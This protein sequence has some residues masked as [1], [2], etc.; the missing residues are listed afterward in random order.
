M[1]RATKAISMILAASAMAAGGFSGG[2]NAA[3]GEADIERAAMS[4][5]R[6]YGH[7][8]P[9]GDSPELE[10]EFKPAFYAVI[11]LKFEPNGGLTAKHAYF[12]ISGTPDNVDC[13]IAFLVSEDPRDHANCAPYAKPEGYLGEPRVP[14]TNTGP[15]VKNLDVLAFG[16]QQRIYVFVDN[17]NV[18][19]NEKTPVSFTPYGAFDDVSSMTVETMDPNLSFY[20]AKIGNIAGGK[21]G[22]MMN[23]YYNGANGEDITDE[24]HPYINSARYSINFNLLMCRG[25]VNKCD[26]AN[27]KAVIPI[28][29]DPDTGNGWGSKP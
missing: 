14:P 8:R 3:D 11:Y 24:A 18:Q 2:A 28:V 5:G 16:S 6:A 27:P 12:P 9:Y 21:R 19:F 17:T 10:M 4:A 7:P 26:F 15:I 20:D 1:T 29:I 25:V 13:A 23:N 22:L